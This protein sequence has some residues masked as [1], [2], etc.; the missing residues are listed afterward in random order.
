MPIPAV[1]SSEPPWIINGLTTAIRRLK[2]EGRRGC[3]DCGSDKCMLR[4]NFW[5]HY[6]DCTMMCFTPGTMGRTYPELLRNRR[7]HLVVLG[8]EVGGRWSNEASS[9]IR[10]L[11]QARA[12]S[13]PPSLRAATASALVSRWCAFFTHAA[14]SSF[15]ASLLFKDLSPIRHQPGCADQ[16]EGL[17]LHLP[18]QK[19]IRTLASTKTVCA[20]TLPSKTAMHPRTF[21]RLQGSEGGKKKPPVSCAETLFS[22]L[23]RTSGSKVNHK[24]QTNCEFTFVMENIC[25]SPPWNIGTLT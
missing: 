12:R 21:L 2:S 15:A 17:G 11:A 22:M 3:F 14:A 9:F 7:C 23:P 13:S 4:V 16:S 18:N 20:W 5:M 1:A 25:I 10:T 19:R 6:Y 8:I 24:Y